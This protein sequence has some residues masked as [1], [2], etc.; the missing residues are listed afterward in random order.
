[1]IKQYDVWLK[2]VARNAPAPTDRNQTTGAWTLGNTCTIGSSCVVTTGC[3]TVSCDAYVAVSPRY[4]SGFQTGEAPGKARVGPNSTRVPAGLLSAGAV[5][6]GAPGVPLTLAKGVAPL[7]SLSWGGSC[8]AG[9]VDYE[10]YEGALSSFTSHTS[11]LCSTSG[12]TTAVITPS[13]SSDYY[14]VVPATSSTEGSYG[15]N[16]GAVERPAGSSA[17]RPQN[18]GSCP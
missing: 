9:A 13:S 16:S 11:L 7:L 8:S 14:L 18:L 10:V 12:A 3:G 17:C 1:V 2:Q 15:K 4:D 5:P 6:D